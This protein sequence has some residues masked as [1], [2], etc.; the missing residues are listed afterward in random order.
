MWW[1]VGDG[2]KGSECLTVNTPTLT[3]QMLH[4]NIPIKYS[5]WFKDDLGKIL[6]T[7]VVLRTR[8]RR[9]KRRKSPVSQESHHAVEES[10]SDILW[11]AMSIPP[12]EVLHATAP[13]G[14]RRRIVEQRRS[15]LKL[16]RQ[17][18]DSWILSTNSLHVQ[19]KPQTCRQKKFC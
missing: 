9:R 15:S 2:G 1:L 3:Y 19:H 13:S 4:F 6:K 11:T 18:K 10:S 16:R 14:S 12:C 8:R 7:S 5:L 17:K